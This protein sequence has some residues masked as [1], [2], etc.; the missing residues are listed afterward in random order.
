MLTCK[1]L[2]W[3]CEFASFSS[4][5]LVLVLAPVQ[6]LTLPLVI[7]SCFP[8][9]P[10]T[11][12]WGQD[13]PPLFLSSWLLKIADPLP[14]VLV[15]VSFLRIDWGCMFLQ[16]E[17]VVPGVN[18]WVMSPKV[19]WVCP[20]LAPTPPTP[21]QICFHGVIL[22]LLLGTLVN[23]VFKF[24]SINRQEGVTSK[25]T[26]LSKRRSFFRWSSCLGA[27]AACLLSGEVR[28]W[29]PVLRLVLSSCPFLV[30]VKLCLLCYW[31]NV[32]SQH[33]KMH[34][35]YCLSWTIRLWSRWLLCILQSDP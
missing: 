30:S 32:S 1:S 9:F 25:G 29:R 4:Y 23:I 31:A 17:H 8:F 35:W 33:A 12:H 5:I 13:A 3:T 27:S 10:I 15:W 2:S 18:F 16:T 28:C 24:L 26:L 14:R 22:V 6:E 7:I 19:I 20:D 11:S 21:L 34:T